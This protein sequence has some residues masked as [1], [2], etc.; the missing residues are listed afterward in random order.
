MYIA[1]NS[2]Y[3]STT[4]TSGGTNAYY[5]TLLYGSEIDNGGWMRVDSVSSNQIVIRMARGSTA[6]FS[7]VYQAYF[8]F[9]LPRLSFS[10]CNSVTMYSNYQGTNFRSFHSCGA[11]SGHLWIR[12]RDL[13]NSDG[14]S[15][16][17]WAGGEQYTF[18]FNLNSITG[19]WTD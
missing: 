11:S 2:G 12:Y 17:N 14:Q 18:T 13:V 15:W 8:R 1:T 6:T 3:Y 5:E 7:Y 19:D 4:E 10:S 9:Y 16:P